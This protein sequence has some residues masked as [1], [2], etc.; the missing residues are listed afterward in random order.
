MAGQSYEELTEH[1]HALS[2]VQVRELG[3]AG[4]YPLWAVEQG[5]DPQ[6]PT[7]LV[8]GGTHGDEP[9]SPAAVLA[10]CRRGA[11]PWLEAFNFLALPCL[12]PHGYAHG[13]R[14]NAQ[15]VDINWAYKRDD[16][17]EIQIVRAILA[18][19]RFAFVVDFHEDW[20]S[21]GFYLYELYR[22]REPLGPQIM[23]QVSSI[24]PLNT[25]PVIEGQR[26]HGGVI[27]PAA[28]KHEELRG[29]GIPVVLYDHHTD[30]LVVTETPTA[31]PIEERV[32][33]QLAT[34]E[35]VVSAY[36]P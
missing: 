6:R 30:H 9:A 22:H 32:R 4:Q 27:V 17:P 1:L 24:C 11:G 3:R 35:V 29:E 20:E 26:A 15:D 12:N 16:V 25:H 23:A 10:F 19:R 21:P 33:A 28:E 13:T 8:I 36:L 5:H 18:D 31:L 34:L 2:G 7:A 14:H